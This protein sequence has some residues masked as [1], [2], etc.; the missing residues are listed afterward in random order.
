MD[1][2]HTLLV[3]TL[4]LTSLRAIISEP[5]I[6]MVT[7]VSG[8]G[9]RMCLCVCIEERS[10]DITH[11]LHFLTSVQHPGIIQTSMTH[12]ASHAAYFTTCSF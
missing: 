8:K 5:L 11:Y 10:P 12:K 4:A 1:A 6:T 3:L 7:D 9:G 2:S